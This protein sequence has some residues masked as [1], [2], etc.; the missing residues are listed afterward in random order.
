MYNADMYVAWYID[1]PNSFRT[2]P[3]DDVDIELNPVLGY[4]INTPSLCLGMKYMRWV[5][6]HR[7]TVLSGTKIMYERY[8]PNIIGTETELES[9]HSLSRMYLGRICL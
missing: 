5:Q 2:V 1:V 4:G 9:N 3:N 7:G 6:W 8:V